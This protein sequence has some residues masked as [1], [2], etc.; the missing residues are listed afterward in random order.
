[1]AELNSNRKLNIFLAHAS[2]DKE[3]VRVLYHRFQEDGID[4]WLDEENLLPGENWRREIPKAVRNADAVLVCLSNNSVDKDGYFQNEIQFALDAAK[5]HSDDPI[6][7]IPLKLEECQVPESLADWHWVDLFDA[8]GYTRLLDALR[9]RAATLGVQ[10]PIAQ[11]DTPFMPTPRRKLKFSWAYVVG[12]ITILAALAGFFADMGSIL[13]QLGI[14]TSALPTAISTPIETPT[15]TFVAV[16]A[17]S[18]TA[19]TTAPT[20][21][22]ILSTDTPRPTNTPRPNNTP[23]PALPQSGDLQTFEGIDFV[24]VPSGTFIMGSTDEE[25]DY[26]LELCEQYWDALQEKDECE[27]SWYEDEQPLSTDIEVDAFWIMQFE[28]TNAQFHDFVEGDGYT[29]QEYWTDAGWKWK[30][31]NAITSPNLWSDN[32]FKGDDKP[33]VGI[34]WYE[35][36]AYTEW[37]SQKTGRDFRLPTEAE[38][39]KAARGSDGRIFSWGNTWESA[40]VNYCDTNC[41]EAWGDKNGNDGHRY[42]APVGSFE[43]KSPYNAYDMSGN[44][45]EWTSSQGFYSYE[46]GERD[47]SDPR[48]MARGGDWSGIPNNVRVAIRNY[49]DPGKRDGAMGVR[50]VLSSGS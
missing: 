19:P 6:Y 27:R 3:T 41:S 21:T 29:N 8:R 33:V 1:M 32:R 12:T 14:S 48:L 40:I 49:F 16:E 17:T 31:K 20:Y 10:S 36:T 28:V 4:P 43:N 30:E 7:L 46:T 42:T 35:S 23:T 24:Y 26:A 45:S 13:A 44:A 38:W 9:K 39:E 50:L 34:S 2:E 25:V 37:L 22:A 11:S 18:I 15:N 47:P 5:K